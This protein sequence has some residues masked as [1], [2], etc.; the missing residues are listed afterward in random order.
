MKIIK[1]VRL[2]NEKPKTPKA[3]PH[4]NQHLLEG[5]S[6]LRMAC[7]TAIM[8]TAREVGIPWN[9]RFCYGIN[10]ADHVAQIGDIVVV[11]TTS[12]GNVFYVETQDV[13]ENVDGDVHKFLCEDKVIAIKNHDKWVFNLNGEK[14]YEELKQMVDND[15]WVEN[16]KEKSAAII[17][18]EAELFATNVKNKLKALGD[19]SCFGL[20]EDDDG[21]AYFGFKINGTDFFQYVKP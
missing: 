10:F 2:N 17:A 21:A 7:E 18:E 9:G 15:L 1:N 20:N 5:V 3:Y 12:D 6:T 11:P 14:S 16:I 8:D 19:V 4:W 13:V